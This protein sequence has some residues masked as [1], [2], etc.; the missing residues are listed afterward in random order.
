MTD[1]WWARKLG[2]APA[3]SPQPRYE[4]PSGPPAPFVAPAFNRPPNVAEGGPP[5]AW[6]IDGNGEKRLNVGAW[7]GG[8]GTKTEHLTCPNCGSSHYFSRTNAEGGGRAGIINK[9]GDFCPPAPQCANCSYNGQF[10]IFG[11]G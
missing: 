11:G 3:N 5:Q 4:G 1:S 9:N 6:V 8:A 10:M 2:R 7:Q